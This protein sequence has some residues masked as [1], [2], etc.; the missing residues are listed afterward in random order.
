[1]GVRKPVWTSSSFLLDAGGLIVLA[2][3]VWSLGYLAGQ[4]GSG[5]FAGWSLL[6]LVVLAAI[7]V[8]F[9]RSG[10]WIAAGVFAVAAVIA[11]AVFIGALEQWFGWLPDNRGSA[12]GGFNVPV[13]L[14]EV[15]TLF[16]A[17]VAM[18][19]FSFPLL[20]A[21]VAGT[22]W[23]FVTDLISGGGNWSAVVTFLVGLFFMGVAAAIDRTSRRPYGFWMHVAAGLL[24]GGSLI[25]FWHSSDANWALVAVAGI[26]YI[27]FAA[28][29]RRS[30]WA[31]LGTVGLF[32]SA[33]HFA[34]EWSGG[35]LSFFGNDVRRDWAPLVVFA[36]LGFLL[37]LLG[38]GL[39]RRRDPLA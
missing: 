36:V 13:L 21:I 11:Y 30:S 33:A 7:A 14:I 26:V 34:N 27:G 39:E 3:A 29:L 32:L 24:I 5:A 1:V 28:G 22:A 31:V 16:A 23:F 15:L 2:A 4:Y 25:Y 8:G 19:V 38:L 20:A 18:L 12:F 37:V 6:V 10:R 17:F 9:R 35:V